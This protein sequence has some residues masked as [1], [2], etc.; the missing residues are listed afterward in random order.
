VWL[1][2]PTL[3]GQ[4][5]QLEPLSDSHRDGL[6]A[7]AD[8]ERIWV[9][10][11]SVARGPGFEAWFDLAL[12]EGHAGQRV[13]F[14][15]RQRADG[16]LIG[17]SSYLDLSERHHR[18]EIGA[19]WYAPEQW[20]TKVNPECKLLLLRHAFEALGVNRVALLTDVL[21]KR[22]QAA[23]A[24]LGAVREG[25]LRSHM[26]SQGGR[27]RD[28]VLFSITAGEWPAVRAGLAARL[29]GR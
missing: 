5:V 28:S 15:V 10:A 27:I 23:I 17:S 25:V 13:P 11:L 19:T 29:A 24:K 9:H 16:R 1:D 21:N 4:W 6:R 7:A 22:S 8:D 12:K 3:T 26:I 2:A 20:G 18:L 14:A